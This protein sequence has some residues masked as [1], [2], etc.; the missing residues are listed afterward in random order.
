[1]ATKADC[2]AAAMKGGLTRQEA[3]LAVNA[4]FEDKTKVQAARTEGKIVNAERAMAEAWAVR[5]DEAKAAAAVARQRATGNVLRRR[6]LEAR[7]AAARAEGFTGMDA[8]EALLVGSNKRFTGA[9][10]SID[11]ARIAL[12]KDFLGALWNDLEK[13]A[14]A[15]PARDILLKDQ[16]F[17]ADVAREIVTPGGAKDATAR[18]VLAQ[19]AQQ[20]RHALPE[21]AGRFGP[22]RHGEDVHAFFGEKSGFVQLA[23][24]RCQFGTNCE[25]IQFAVVFVKKLMNGIHGVAIPQTP[26][27]FLCREK[28][29]AILSMQASWAPLSECTS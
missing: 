25:Y 21:L 10:N 3:E 29:F 24:S 16:G 23:V 2:I 4:L 9:R 1:M 26:A 18:A 28:K 7:F 6:K 22:R 14:G 11:A 15:T 12:K 27:D 8:L 20:A 5:M 19:T 13:I 17:T